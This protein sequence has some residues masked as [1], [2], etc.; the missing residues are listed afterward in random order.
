MPLKRVLLVDDH[1]VFRHGVKRLLTEALPEV[2]IAE[3]VDGLSAIEWIR[4]RACDLVL[5]DVTLPGPDGLEVLK[6]LRAEFPHVPVL[7]VSMH[8]ADQ[9]ARRMIAA[10]AIGYVTKDTD[11]AELVRAVSL[12]LKGQRYL[13][14]DADAGADEPQPRHERLS[15]REYQVLRMLAAGRTVSQ[16]ADELLLSVN[17]VSTYRARILEK[18]EMESNAELMRYAMD[19]G[20][21]P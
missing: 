6:A 2:D 18:M 12:A 3:A 13:A 21:V 16:I 7:I 10:G 5:L 9:F 14:S 4:P 1:P 8:P 11:P 19:Q 15:D 20:L 17:T